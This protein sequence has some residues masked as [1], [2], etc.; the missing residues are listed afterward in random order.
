MK[1]DEAIQKICLFK[2]LHI[3][4]KWSNSVKKKK[5]TIK[6]AL[7]LILVNVFL[8]FCLSFGGPEKGNFI[9]GLEKHC[10]VY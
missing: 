9:I 6:E 8:S 5:K 2:E 3:Y 7:V 10:W 1:F 4:P